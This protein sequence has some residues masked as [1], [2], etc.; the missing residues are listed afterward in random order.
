MILSG[1]GRALRARL[2]MVSLLACAAAA[3]FWGSLKAGGD[4]HVPPTPEVGGQAMGAAAQPREIANAYPPATS[5]GL[6]RKDTPRIETRPHDAADILKQGAEATR[7]R[8]AELDSAFLAVPINHAW[9]SEH[10]AEIDATIKSDIAE[11]TDLIPDSYNS[12]CRDGMCRIEAGFQ[13][14]NGVDSWG[15]FVVGGL[16]KSFPRTRSLIVDDGTGS[17]TIVL[18]V[19]E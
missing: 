17:S 11:V 9:A 8:I 18:Y 5:R 19:M 12:S 16:A 1:N 13:N 6:V 7:R 4:H 2:A 10:K 14:S 3:V 15:D